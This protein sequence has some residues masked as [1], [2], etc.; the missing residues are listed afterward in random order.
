MGRRINPDSARQKKIKRI[1]E[2]GAGSPFITT[3]TIPAKLYEEYRE[4]GI[5]I[6]RVERKARFNGIRSLTDEIMVE[7]LE[8]FV[9]K[10]A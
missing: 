6:G 9:K 5:K 7:A 3:A 10:N 1:S 8:Q 2:R 4:I